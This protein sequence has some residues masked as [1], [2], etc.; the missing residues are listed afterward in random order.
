M[1]ALVLSAVSLSIF[2]GSA[3]AA[4]GNNDPS[5]VPT[6][7]HPDPVVLLHGLG[8]TY[9]EDLN[10]LQAQLATDGYCTYSLTYGSPPG[11]PYVG[12]LAAI[13]TSAPQIAQFVEQVLAETRAAKV[14]LVGHSEGAFQSL[15]VT[16]TQGIADRID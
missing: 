4:G 1:I 10:L 8:A 13:A 9:Y 15:Y 2:A 14:D 16:K 11:F 12:G 3:L 7:A 5:C 6:A